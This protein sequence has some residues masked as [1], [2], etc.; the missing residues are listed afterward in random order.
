MAINEANPA[1]ECLYS[2]L[3]N[4]SPTSKFFGFIP[5]HGRR[6]ACG[7]EITVFGHIQHWLMKYTPNERGRRSLE[8]ALH[9]ADGCD[10]KI[11]IVKTPAP[12]LL[13]TTR[14]RTQIL[15]LDAGGFV[16]ADPCWG[17]ASSVSIACTDD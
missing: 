14:D 10:P 3:R 7:E 4:V 11:A 6:L 2:T 9:P 17:S 16:G 13:D 15:T 8:D 1:T 12:H 5:P